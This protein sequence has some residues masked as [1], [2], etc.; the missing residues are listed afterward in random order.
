[1]VV[2]GTGEAIILLCLVALPL[3]SMGLKSI[4]AAKSSTNQPLIVISFELYRI[5]SD[6]FKTF[7]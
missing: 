2:V 6:D 5:P 7:I 1:M 3:R 4:I